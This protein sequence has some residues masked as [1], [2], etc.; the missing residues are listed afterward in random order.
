MLSIAEDKK[1]PGEPQEREKESQK[2]TWMGNQ[3]H[4]QHENW[5]AHPIPLMP[6]P[7]N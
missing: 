5:A 3:L 4:F 2:M 6:A 1:L 7:E